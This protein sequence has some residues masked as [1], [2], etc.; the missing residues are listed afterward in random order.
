[1]LL[2]VVQALAGAVEASTAGV[3]AFLGGFDSFSF[4]WQRDIATEHAKFLTS[5]PKLEVIIQCLSSLLFTNLYFLMLFH[6][7]LNSFFLLFI[8]HW[9]VTAR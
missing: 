3:A 8:T 6:Y 4:L 1:M 5:N 2:Q 9:D 7:L